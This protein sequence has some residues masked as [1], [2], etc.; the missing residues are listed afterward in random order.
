[1]KS[2]AQVVQTV[3][4]KLTHFSISVIPAGGF[5]YAH[6]VPVMNTKGT[7]ISGF[8][9]KLNRQ[10]H[11]AAARQYNKKY[12]NTGFVLGFFNFSKSFLGNAIVGAYFVEPFLAN[13]KKFSLSPQAAIG[14]SYNSNPHHDLSNSENQ[15]YSLHINPYLS[16]GINTVVKVSEK[17]SLESAIRFNH[18][19]NGAIYH[20]NRGLNFPTISA[21]VKYDLESWK[22]GQIVPPREFKWRYD[23][24][25]LGTW[26]SIP[27]DGK[28]FH[29]LYGLS[30]QVNRKVGWFHGLNAGVELFD[31]LG[32]K[33]KFKIEG[34]SQLNSHRLGILAGHE[35]LFRKF[36]FSQ[37]LGVNIFNEIPTISR[38]YHRWGLYY[39][40]GPDWM[41]GS[42]FS[43][44]KLKADFLDFRVIYSIYE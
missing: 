6:D 16:L 21:G 26:K 41:L 38:L 27:A 43:A 31:D 35:F 19:S 22:T 37:Q 29:G 25:P 18:L 23:I 36:N 11:D 32:I 1:M 2:V 5:V 28:R 33:K 17:Y 7:A 30:I 14:L 20:P 13:T 10:R 24:M 34:E 15:S 12:F 40:I 4:E 9:I 44:H 3:E 39:R 42:N 8:E